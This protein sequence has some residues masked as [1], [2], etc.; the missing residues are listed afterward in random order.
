VG[1]RWIPGE[2]FSGDVP[3]AKPNPEFFFAAAR[4]LSLT[5]EDCV[6]VGDTLHADIAGANA[7]GIRSIWIDRG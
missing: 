5:P 3:W 1:H 6:V 4:E 7:A 2:G